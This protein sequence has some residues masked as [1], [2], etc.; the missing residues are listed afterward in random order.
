M[1]SRVHSTSSND[2]FEDDEQAGSEAADNDD[3]NIVPDNDGPVYHVA[4]NVLY[5]TCP[6]LAWRTRSALLTFFPCSL[7]F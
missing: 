1:Q 7:H 4:K 3:D 6:S 5:L 2:D